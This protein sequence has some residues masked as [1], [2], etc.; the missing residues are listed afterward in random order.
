MFEAIWTT[1][2]FW[3]KVGVFVLIGCIPIGIIL[4]INMNGGWIYIDDLK[5]KFKKN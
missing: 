4:H 5:R 3:Q 2:D 1:L